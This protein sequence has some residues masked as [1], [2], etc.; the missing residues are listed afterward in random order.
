VTAPAAVRVRAT[1][2]EDFPAIVAL[3]HAV[4][5]GSPAWSPAQ[6]ASHLSVFPEGQLVAV[7]AGGR[8]VGMAASLIVRWDDYEMTT[9][10][11]DFTA[12]GT[13]TNHDP[14][15]GRTLYAA[16]VMVHP[17]AQGHGVGSALYDARR[18]L[19]RRLRLRRIRAGARLRGY[20][21][22][23]DRMSAEEYVRRVIRGEI[24]DSTL[25][26]QLHRGFAVIG[27]APDY[28]RHDPESLGWAAVIEWLNDEVARPEDAAARDRWRAAALESS[29]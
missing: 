13:F 7:D 6:L 28:L 18:D 27:L 19:A 26:F 14:E 11:R 15:S 23:A 24:Q 20:H 4:Y 21:R 12:G 10:W 3:T 9:G 22:F 29:P 2:P 16:E 8:L 25:S 1:R 5:P 17:A